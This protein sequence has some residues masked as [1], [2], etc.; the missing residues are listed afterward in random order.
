MGRDLPPFSRELRADV[1]TSH[2]RP[3]TVTSNL[4]LSLSRLTDGTLEPNRVSPL[5][6]VKRP[7]TSKLHFP[8]CLNLGAF[9][10]KSLVSLSA[11]RWLARY[12]LLTKLKALPR[13]SQALRN[14][15]KPCDALNADCVILHQK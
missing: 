11:C 2:I 15:S 14:S 6:G 8:S 4:T 3:Q 13:S 5:A 10:T 9:T 1:L 12:T 7:S